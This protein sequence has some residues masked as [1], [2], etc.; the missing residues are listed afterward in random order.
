M[1]HD[2]PRPLTYPINAAAHELSISRASLY[3]LVKQQ[4]L[5]L[6][7]VGAKSVITTSSIMRL[8]GEA[9]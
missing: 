7:K 2:H 6:R 8:I 4:K 3:R 5:E 1:Q 9:A